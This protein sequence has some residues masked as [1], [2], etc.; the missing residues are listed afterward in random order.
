[1]KIINYKP[2]VFCLLLSSSVF[3]SCSSIKKMAS[4]LTVTVSNSSSLSKTAET[5]EIPW[6]NLQKLNGLNA[7]EIIVKSKDTGK[8]IPSQVIYNGTSSPQSIIFQTDIKA[9]SSQQFTIVNGVPAKYP[10]KVFGRQVPERFDDFAWENDKVA[11]RMYGEA[12]ESKKG[13]AKGLDFWAKKTSRMIV[14][15][16]YKGGDYHKDHGDAVDA[17]HVGMTL[18]AGG[19]EPIVGDEIIYP[20]NYSEYK[21]LDNGPIRFSFQLIYKPFLVNGKTVKEVKM[22]SLDAGSQLNK[23]TNNYEAPSSLD[24]ASGVTKHKGDGTVKIDEQNNYVAYWDK[25]DG[26][27]ANGYMGVGVIYPAKSLKY[28]KETKQHVLAVVNGGKDN[29]IT[30]Y[31]GGGWSKSGNFDTVESW[32]AYLANFSEN[33]KKPLNIQVN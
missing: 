12:L 22:V 4:V 15:E 8:E 31:Q 26:G 14:N 21:I 28:T 3:M 20:I 5:V 17:Y 6:Q 10:A 32:F 24:I 16:L 25:G 33:L 18:G 1:M 23:V 29:Q 27:M 19:A 7:K 30:Y 13:M 2:I 9:G 11:F